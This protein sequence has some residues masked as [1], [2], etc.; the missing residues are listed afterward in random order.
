MVATSS[1]TKSRAAGA[2]LDSSQNTSRA[3]GQSDAVDAKQPIS[4]SEF[5]AALDSFVPR[6][7]EN[8]NACPIKKMASAVTPEVMEKINSILDNRAIVA[9]QIE[10]FFL[11]W[12]SVTGIRVG[13]QS[14]WKH[15]RR[16]CTCP[17]N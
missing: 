16:D 12:E 11:E 6:A 4:L 8:G 5:E 9:K 1:K 10:T 7:R 2:A 14:I 13:M 15:R 17:K 3:R